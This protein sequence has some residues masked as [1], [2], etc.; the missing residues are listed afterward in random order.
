[1]YAFLA[2]LVLAVHFAFVAF[3]A[4]G[5]LLVLKWRRV[6]WIHIP[7]A[8]WGVAIEFAGWICPL[9]PLENRW[10]ELAGEQPYYGDFIARYLLPI[11]YPEGLTREIQ[12]ALG[13]SALLV[14]AAVYV[15]VFR[16]RSQRQ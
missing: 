3:V 16:R 11:V 7:A 8:A 4:L 2:D 15:W 10:R 14:N 5:G 6:A 1:M 12:I 13:L 9:T